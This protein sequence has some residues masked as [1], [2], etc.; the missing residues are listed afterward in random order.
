[1]QISSEAVFSLFISVAENFKTNEQPCNGPYLLTLSLLAFE[2]QV[3]SPSSNLMIH[4]CVLFV[5]I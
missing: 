4:N 3:L 1:M 5:K 2:R